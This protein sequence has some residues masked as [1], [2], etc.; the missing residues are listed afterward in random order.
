MTFL[1]RIVDLDF[2]MGYPMDG[3]DVS[4]SKFRGSTVYQV[5]ILR[6]FGCTYEGKC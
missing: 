6:L 2:Y 1:V 5:P 3:L 4:Y